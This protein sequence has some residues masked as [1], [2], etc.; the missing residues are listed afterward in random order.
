MSYLEV[1]G[2]TI[3]QPS[4]AEL[5]SDIPAGSGFIEPAGIAPDFQIPLGFQG[6]DLVYWLVDKKV[7]H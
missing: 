4:V 6:K 7:G 1:T 2:Y 5:T 3:R